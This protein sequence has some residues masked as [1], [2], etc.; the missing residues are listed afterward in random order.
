MAKVGPPRRD[1]FVRMPALRGR[2]ILQDNGR[3]QMVAK[4][5]PKKRKRPLHPT[6]VE[7]NKIFGTA[8]ALSKRVAPDI[9][10]AAMS[11]THR[12]GL[13]PRDLI[14]KALYGKLIA[15]RRAGSRTMI[16]MSTYQQLSDLLDLITNIEGQYLLRGPDGWI[17]QDQS[18]GGANWDYPIWNEFVGGTNSGSA[19]AFKGS[20]FR[21]E[22][23]VTILAARGNFT[24]VYGASYKFVVCEINSSGVIQSIVSSSTYVADDSEAW[25]REFEIA[26]T[27][28]NGK[29]YAVM[30]GR[31]DAADTYAFPCSYQNT[32]GWHLPA[33]THKRAQLAKA[34]PATGD[35]VNIAD[36]YS[37]PIG[38]NI[39]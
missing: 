32:I 18:G 4:A 31:T 16:P 6:T 11:V 37:H 13:Y 2:L 15:L 9:Y 10:V 25:T 39:A 34:D 27:M 7:Q 28:E 14:I 29:D 26:T 33:R 1:L 38:L 20:K 12:T 21:C 35:T 8:V 17:G 3:G 24:A 22:D 36:Y 19:F 5:W 30:M 23:D